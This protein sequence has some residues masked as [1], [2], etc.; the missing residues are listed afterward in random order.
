MDSTLLPEFNEIFSVYLQTIIW[1]KLAR[2]SSNYMCD[3][4]PIFKWKFARG[5]ISE[6]YGFPITNSDNPII[7]IGLEDYDHPV[8]MDN[9]SAILA[10]EEV[11]KL[12]EQ[13]IKERMPD[14]APAI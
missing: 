2:S 4:F 5:P 8:T 7:K 10:P 13:H 1:F 12:Y 9:Y 11:H 14:L 3:R 6:L